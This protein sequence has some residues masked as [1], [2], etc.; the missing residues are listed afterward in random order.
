MADNRLKREE[1][2]KAVLVSIALTAALALVLILVLVLYYSE[3]LGDL[4]GDGIL[5]ILFTVLIFQLPLAAAPFIAIRITSMIVPD[6]TRELVH[7]VFLFLIVLGSLLFALLMLL[8]G[9][10]QS[11]VIA[12][13]QI[14]VGWLAWRGVRRALRLDRRTGLPARTGKS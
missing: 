1:N 4:S 6:Y 11:I 2:L 3:T 12:L 13:I 9:G 7:Y 8:G 14:P 5:K 10:W